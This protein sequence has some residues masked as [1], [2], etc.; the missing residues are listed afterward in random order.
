[1]KLAIMQPY[2]L[3]YIGYYQLIR[4]ADIFVYYDDVNFI[5]QSWINR[6]RI[7]LNGS[8][9]LFTLELKGA[10][11]F[12]R[13]MD[14]EVG[15]NRSKLFKTICQAYKNSNNYKKLEPLLFS[16]FASTEKNLS[17][18]I[19]QTQQ[20]IVN[21][22]GIKTVCLLSSELKK[23]CSLKG[24]NKVIDICKNLGASTYINSIGGQHLYSENDFNKSGIKL[25][26][27]KPITTNYTQF[28]NNHIPWLSII[29]VMMFNEV[30]QIKAMLDKYYLI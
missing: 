6:N 2:F 18:Y 3:P 4:A 28:S 15:R 16:I 25:K 5:K 8:D 7:L 23:D 24:H 26:F 10:S 11:S 14:I 29:D 1:M 21:Y 27:L 19:I 22:L 30:S 20:Y 9:Y 13:I 17:K 12:K